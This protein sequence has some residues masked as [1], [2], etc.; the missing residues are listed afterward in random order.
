MNLDY[1][2]IPLHNLGGILHQARHSKEAALILH[3]AIDIAP[4]QD[5]HY[6]AIGNVYAALGDYNRSVT[7]YDKFLDLK[8]GQK[9]VVANKHATL[10][11]WKL[12]N[13]LISFQE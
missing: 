9:D 2:D 4:N 7:Y 11:Y 12:E 6:L 3:S 1:Q 13:G 10:C 5:I 8:P